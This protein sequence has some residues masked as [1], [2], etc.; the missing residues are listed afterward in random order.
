MNIIS[1]YITNLIRADYMG[2]PMSWFNKAVLRLWRK[3]Y[4]YISKGR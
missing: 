3:G 2:I 1:R 4:K